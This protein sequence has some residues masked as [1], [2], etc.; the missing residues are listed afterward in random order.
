MAALRSIPGVCAVF[1]S[2]DPP[3]MTRTPSC[4]HL[5]VWPCSGAAC[6]SVIIASPA[7]KPALPIVTHFQQ[8]VSAAGGFLQLGDDFAGF[9]ESVI[10]R[11]DAAIDRLLH[12]D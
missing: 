9:L 10:G 3:G 1:G 2:S 6:N 5:D 8:C 4:F 7:K 11:R 12:D